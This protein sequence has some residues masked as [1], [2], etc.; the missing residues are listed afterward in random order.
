MKR[1]LCVIFVLSLLCSLIACSGGDKNYSD[2]IPCAELLDAAEEQIPIDLGYESFGGDHIKYYFDNTELDDDHALRYSVK[3]ENVN[4]IG[5]FHAPDEDSRKK[6]EDLA[7]KYI[8]DLVEDRG[9][10]I[11]SYAPD[12]LD[13]LRGGEVRVY[14]NYIAYAILSEAEKEHFFDAIEKELKKEK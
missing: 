10:F 12:E 7:K 9:S 3:S 4:E 14:G 5:I 11:A 6:L 2:S 8:S 1:I 13:K